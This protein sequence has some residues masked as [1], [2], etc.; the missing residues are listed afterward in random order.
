MTVPTADAAAPIFHTPVCEKLGIRWPI[1]GFSHEID[2]VV[3]ICRAGGFGV[4]GVAREDPKRI[5]ELISRLR[6]AVGDAPFGVDLMLPAGMPDRTP[7]REEVDARIP[8]QHKVFVERLREK[9][10][11]PPATRQTFFTSFVRSRQLFD[12]QVEAVLGSEVP[13]IATAVG[14]PPEV[15]ARAK[16]AGKVTLSLIGTPKHARAALAAGADILVAQGYDAGGHTGTIGTLSLVPQIVEIAAPSGVP[17]IAAGGIATGAQ[18]LAAI[19]MGAQGAWLGTVWLGARENHTH[20]ALLDKLV[21]AGSEDTV[22]TRAHSG[23]P[24]RVVRSAWSEEWAAPGAPAPLPMPYQHALTGELLAAIEEHDV[25]P[26]VYEAAGQSVAW[27]T[28]ERSVAQI[29]DALLDE[30]RDGWARMSGLAARSGAGT[31]AGA[32]STGRNPSTD[33]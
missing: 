2:V 6:T 14:L 7:T 17:V 27:L 10:A 25:K 1:F 13:L 33:R 15:I 23:K 32:H 9:Y 19:A 16:A 8:E 31:P 28:G 12:E 26:L 20:R 11:V 24:C 29:V 4:F 21:A 5:P 30:M 3:A 18:I 22:I